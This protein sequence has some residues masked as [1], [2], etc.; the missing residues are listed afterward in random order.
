MYLKDYFSNIKKKYS[1][2]SFSN[3]T[4][5]SSKVKKNYIFFAI[6]G[7][8]FDGH[9][10]IGKAIEKGSRII[11]YEKKFT[12]L[13][14]GILFL[15]SKNIRK[16]LAQI[17]FRLNSSI[18]SNLVAVTGTN[19]KSS[20]A[21]F[22]FQILKLNNKKVASIGTLGIKTNYSFNE[23]PNTT[24]DPINLGKILTKLKK[25]KIENVIME[26]SSHGLDQNRLDGLK[27]NVG[28]FTNLSH[29]HLDYHKSM[30]KYLM[31][32]LYL[33]KNLINKNKNVVTDKYISQYAILKKICKK[34]SL[35]LTTFSEN[36]KHS[37]I[38]LKSYK[39]DG[40]KLIIEI[41]NRNK[42]Y[43]ISLN[44]IGKVQIKNLMMAVIA[45]EK[46]NL[47]LEKI[48]K[49]LP[50]IK[51]ING[52]LENIGKIKNDSKVVLDYAH[53]PDALKTAL[54]NLRDQF[55]NKRIS[56]VFGCGGERDRFKR[57]IMGYIASQYCKKIY[58]T[59]DNPRNEN[60]NSIRNEIKK[61]IN[62]RKIFEIKDRKKA[63]REAILNL[64]SSEIL[65]IA[66]KG[67]ENSQTYKN[68][69]RFFSDKNII[70]ESIHLKNK[71]LSNDIKLNIIKEISKTKISFKNL[72]SNKVAIN[73]KLVKKNDIFFTIKGKKKD[74]HKYLKEVSQNKALIAI[75]EKIRNKLRNTKQLKVKNTL[76]FLTN[77]AKKYRESLNSKIIAITGS[78]GKT[79][80]K[81]MLG[82]SLN[83]FYQ[84][85]YS[86][87][88]FN[89]KYG[90]PLS[91]LSIKKGDKFGVLEV[92]MD[93]KGEI[94][95]LSNII[96]PNVGVITNI[97]FAHIK[98]FNNIS[99]IAAA[100]GEI[101]NNI[102]SNGYLVL[103]ADDR[104]FNFHRKLAFKKKIKI[105]SFSKN[106]KNTTVNIKKIIKEKN[107]YKV[108]LKIKNKERYFYIRKN[109]DNFLYNLLASIT[110]MQIY[111]DISKLNKNL[112]LDSKTTQGR[113]DISKVKINKK[114]IFLIDESYNSNPL[115][116]ESALQNFNKIKVNYKKKYLVLGD[117]LELGKHSKKLHLTIAK[118]INKILVNKVY[119]IG[120]DIKETFKK[121]HKNKKGFI[122]K[123]DSQLNDLIKNRLSDGDYLM[124]KGS[125]S[126]GLFNYV[127][128]LKGRVRDAL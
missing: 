69:V 34:N 64:K 85:T 90:V 109:F 62:G 101:I 99:Q 92:G 57:P 50:K 59:D 16:Q 107:R 44:L 102:N 115:S 73:S 110:I 53:T 42:D 31:A 105:L 2:Y 18:P 83:K 19:G 60:P 43:K 27:F 112:F 121:I 17:S 78:C 95:F 123:N 88:S 127:S 81:D 20:V 120:K 22:Y 72:R 25:Q 77:S 89:N 122:L 114:K 126:T 1:K 68:K 87:K 8:N 63:I 15:Y 49:C 97:S 10:F 117:M 75:V 124:I 6:K 24:I 23:L 21:D 38:K 52:R 41:E 32:K 26:A 84:T 66:G 55:P 39:Y 61:G 79:S 86:K 35:R 54:I 74:A 30:N 36:D 91:L 71:D 28:I 96:K 113:G 33:F 40:E 45:A 46:S 98:N 103:N 106:K 29:D 7:N 4:F 13:K 94:D 82:F 5:D 111:I 104:F 119:V 12:G 56:I 70:I 9:D 116:L 118:S 37:K 67:H 14:N 100:K 93:K 51:P 58:L 108:F 128:K 48:V 11:V 65:L 3:I 80:L 76:K 125:N 47:P